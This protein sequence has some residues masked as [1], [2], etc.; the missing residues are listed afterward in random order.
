MEYFA[1]ETQH[2]LGLA[3]KYMVS[4]SVVKVMLMGRNFFLLL[5]KPNL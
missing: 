1:L 2:S 5:Q 4:V 3:L